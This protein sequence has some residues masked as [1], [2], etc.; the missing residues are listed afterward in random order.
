M[1]STGLPNCEYPGKKK[2]LFCVAPVCLRMNIPGTNLFTCPAVQ[3]ESCFLYQRDEKRS[4]SS[5]AESLQRVLVSVFFYRYVFFS[6]SVLLYIVRI[7]VY[8]FKGL[9]SSSLRVFTCPHT[10]KF[11]QRLLA[12]TVVWPVNVSTAGLGLPSWVVL[13]A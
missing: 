1:C 10:F 7:G 13:L 8:C 12:G 2:L 5:I 3:C 9:L 4:Y 11:R 6:S